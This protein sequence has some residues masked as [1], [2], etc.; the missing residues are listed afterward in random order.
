MV[1][2]MKNEVTVTPKF[3]RCLAFTLPSGTVVQV[4]V[5][6]DKVQAAL[7]AKLLLAALSQ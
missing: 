5:L 2:M 1:F 3:N 4:K 7:D 6:G